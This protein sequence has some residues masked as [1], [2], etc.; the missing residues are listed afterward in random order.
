M[1]SGQIAKCRSKFTTLLSFNNIFG[2]M[3][4]VLCGVFIIGSI[5]L[6]IITMILLIERERISS[7][8]SFP[9]R[10]ILRF[11][12]YLGRFLFRPSA[13]AQTQCSLLLYRNSRQEKKVNKWSTPRVRVHDSQNNQGNFLV[14]KQG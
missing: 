5:S 10:E 1:G 13:N 12:Y 11:T 4:N 2:I 14:Q 6:T 8:F 9:G 7:P 3:K